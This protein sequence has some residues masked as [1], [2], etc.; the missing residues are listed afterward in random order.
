MAQ[1]RTKSGRPVQP[2][3][4]GVKSVVTNKLVRFFIILDDQPMQLVQCQTVKA[5]DYLFSTYYVF[6]KDY[7]FGWRNTMHFLSTCFYKVFEDP[8]PRRRPDAV[9]PSES[10]L[11]MMLNQE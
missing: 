5:L 10:E 6:N 2:Y 9:T 4:M 3:L 11:W 7:P 8:I 1:K